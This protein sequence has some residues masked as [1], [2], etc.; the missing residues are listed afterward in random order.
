LLLWQGVHLPLAIGLSS[1][2]KGPCWVPT[3]SWRSSFPLPLGQVCQGGQGFKPYVHSFHHGI[4]A[5]VANE[6]ARPLLM[7]STMESQRQ[8]WNSRGNGWWKHPWKDETRWELQCP[9]SHQHTSPV[10]VTFKDFQQQRL[11]GAPRIVSL[12]RSMQDP[13]EGF[14]ATL[15]PESEF[16]HLGSGQKFPAP[17]RNT[18]YSGT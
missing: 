1:C 16:S 10:A 6:S 9:S 8:W 2:W 14:P 4:P 12:W 3:T 11:R 5:E 18:R 7:L 15:E 17:E 13:N